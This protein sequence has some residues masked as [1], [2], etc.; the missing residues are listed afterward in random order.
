MPARKTCSRSRGIGED[1]AEAISE[2]EKHIDL[3][4][5]LKRIADFGCRVVI[6][7]DAEYPDS[8]REIYDPANRALRKGRADSRRTKTRLRW[9]ARE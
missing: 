1:T 5:E 8:L 9:S 3:A 2:W 6:Q 7:S 4:A